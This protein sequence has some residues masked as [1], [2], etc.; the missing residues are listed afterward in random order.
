MCHHQNLSCQIIFEY[1][2]PS[3]PL[4]YYYVILAC[5]SILGELLHHTK[6]VAV[7]FSSAGV[8]N[9]RGNKEY[10][11]SM[12]SKNKTNKGGH[13]LRYEPM[14]LKLFNE[15]PNA[16]E[17]FRRTGCLHSAIS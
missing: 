3:F 10:K 16:M 7:E 11:A 13:C 6:L 8:T 17:V 12:A 5:E 14:G 15:D 1:F 2:T 9:K 4:S